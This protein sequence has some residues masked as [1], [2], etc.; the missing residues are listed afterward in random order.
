MSDSYDEVLADAEEV[1]INERGEIV[2]VGTKGRRGVKPPKHTFY[3]SF[4]S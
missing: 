2:P 1:E 4:A 3:K